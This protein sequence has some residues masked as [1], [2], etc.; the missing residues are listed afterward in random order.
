MGKDKKKK[1]SFISNNLYM[2]KILFKIS[3]FYVIGTFILTLFDYF[4]WTFNTVFF[5]RYLVDAL[6]KHKSF[7]YV[8]ILILIF[9]FLFLL[10]SILDNLF[11][12]YYIRYKNAEVSYKLNVMLFEKAASVDI[13]CFEHSE[14]YDKY[15]AAIRESDGRAQD[16]LGNMSNIISATLAAIFVLGV[17]FTIDYVIAFFILIPVAI[18]FLLEG[19]SKKVYYQSDLECI[20]F[21]RRQDYVN[22]TILLKKYAKEIRMSKIMSSLEHIYDIGFNGICK[23]V[24]KYKNKMFFLEYVNGVLRFPIGFQLGFMYLAYKIVVVKDLNMSDFIVGATAIVQTAN[25]IA[26]IGTS[27]NSLF[28]NS[29]YISNF[30]TFLN[31]KA[32][33][34]ENQD[35]IIP[36]QIKTIE[37]RNV[38]FTYEGQEA[39]TLKNLNFK[40]NVNQS[41]ALVGHNGAGKSTLIKLIMRLYDV[42]DGEILI[43]N[44]NVKE[45]NIK[46]YRKLIG[47][48]FQNSQAIT[49]T[50]LENVCMGNITDD[51][52]NN[53]INA[54]KNSG[55]YDKIKNLPNGINS[56]VTK[57]F[58][59]NGIE[60]SGGEYQKLAIARA[61]VKNAPIIILD[62][63]SSALDPIAEHTMF[64]NITYLY[65]GNNKNKLVFII[66]HRM[67]CAT[68]TDIVFLLENGEI[69][70]SGS[71]KELMQKN[72]KYAYMFNLQAKYYETKDGELVYE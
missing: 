13:E 25:S 23:T 9:S 5:M 3:P 26:N 2:I 22:R 17:I 38:S 20:P 10:Q 57:E 61:I 27:V 29:L 58:D 1:L 30:K 60:F 50:V 70:E 33:I 6:D 48:V 47:A 12:N 46:A 36:N 7:I 72:D 14:F 49:A 65:K 34:P 39:P 24:D 66:S 18:S 35:G 63:P 55:L 54:L 56:I 21:T 64:E 71:H 44:I 40:I 16:V 62:E 42:S 52:E 67:S 8:T 59:E 37:F 15:V 28:Q 11:Y 31:Y 41:V 45:Y 68:L 43:N 69:I 19:K 32:R 4:V 53:A 51:L